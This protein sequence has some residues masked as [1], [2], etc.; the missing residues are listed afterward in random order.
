MMT[1]DQLILINRA[2]QFLAA[3]KAHIERGGNLLETP[4]PNGKT[5]GTYSARKSGRLARC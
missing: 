4:M 2:E 5:L 1:V 3:E